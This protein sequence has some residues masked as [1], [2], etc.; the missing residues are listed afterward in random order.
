MRSRVGDSPSSVAGRLSA[1]GCQ[2]KVNKE[3]VQTRIR[4]HLKARIS[5][6]RKVSV[7]TFYS[8]FMQCASGNVLQYQSVKV[9]LDILCYFASYLL[10]LKV[11]PWTWDDSSL[12][13][14]GRWP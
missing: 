9:M 3:R 13:I 7:S 12:R 6:D 11:V 4:D 14:H 1:H 2:T 5:K 8:D 10:H